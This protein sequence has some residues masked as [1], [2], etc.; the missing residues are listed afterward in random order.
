[1]IRGIQYIS[2]S[3]DR[4]KYFIRI[5][6]T[7]DRKEKTDIMEYLKNVRTYMNK[8]SFE[9]KKKTFV[10]ITC[11]NNCTF[12]L[13]VF[14]LGRCENKYLCQGNCV[15]VSS[16]IQIYINTDDRKLGKCF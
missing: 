7:V 12:I 11:D 8:V 15:N 1:M 16:S 4:M 5:L 13:R 14:I 6:C 2:L 9:R 3:T 10:S